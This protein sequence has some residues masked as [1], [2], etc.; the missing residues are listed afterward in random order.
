MRGGG[1][2]A[3][4][5]IASTGTGT[6]AQADS[7]PADKASLDVVWLSQLPVALGFCLVVQEE[8]LA[9]LLGTTG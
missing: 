4:L 5:G 8:A 6:Q 9:F 3:F 2:N 1:S 7:K